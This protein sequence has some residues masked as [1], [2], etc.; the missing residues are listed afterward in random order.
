[1]GA[2]RYMTSYRAMN[3]VLA[4]QDESSRLAK[5]AVRAAL[6]PEALKTSILRDNTMTR[7]RNE[8]V[9]SGMKNSIFRR[10]QVSRIVLNEK[11]ASLPG[12]EKA[13]W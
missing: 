1:M 2:G 6:G 12:V 13:T 8:C 3:R 5:L 10:L 7:I 11:W 4:A 9:E